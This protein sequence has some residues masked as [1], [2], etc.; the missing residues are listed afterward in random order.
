MSSADLPPHIQSSLFGELKL[1]E[2]NFPGFYAF[3]YSGAWPH[4]KLGVIEIVFKPTKRDFGRWNAVLKEAEARAEELINNHDAILMTGDKRFERLFKRCG[5]EA[6]Q[7]GAVLSDLRP[8]CLKLVAAEDD[9][10]LYSPCKWFPGF[11]LTVSV[12]RKHRVTS[13][14]FDG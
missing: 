4:P 6:H 7:V 11:D 2:F 8:S 9:E 1:T 10:M 14:G 3:S 13:V 5:I 12:N